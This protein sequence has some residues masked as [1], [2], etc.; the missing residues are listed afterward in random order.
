MRVFLISGLGGGFGYTAA[1]VV[2][3]Y[4]FRARRNIAVGIAMSGV[5]V[6]LCVFAPVMQLARDTYG[7]RGFFIILA[8]IEC[9]LITFGMLCFP[10]KQEIYSHVSRKLAN[11]ARNYDK[12][13]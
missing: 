10:S 12:N 4:N 2:V 5:S 3:S 13:R 6:G 7:N 9:N 11:V 8:A 1:T